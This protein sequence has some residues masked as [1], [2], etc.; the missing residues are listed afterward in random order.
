MKKVSGI[1]LPVHEDDHQDNWVPYPRPAKPIPAHTNCLINQLAEIDEVA[2]D[3]TDTLYG[4]GDKMPRADL[5]EKVDRWRARLLEWS[6]G[7]PA[8]MDYT[9]RP[10]PGILTLQ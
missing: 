9:K 2:W 7:V 4:D 1:R 5:E 8:C 6:R 10:L 3:A